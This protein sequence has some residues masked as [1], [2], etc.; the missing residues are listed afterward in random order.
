MKNPLLLLLGAA[1]AQA[2]AAGPP[3]ASGDICRVANNQFTGAHTRGRPLPLLQGDPQHPRAA[4]VVPWSTLSP[5]GHALPV[6]G[7]FEGRLLQLPND[8][9]CGRGTG[10]LW[11]NRRW[12]LTR[13]DT[14]APK[15]ALALCEHL[16]TTTSAATRAFCITQP[17]A[18]VKAAAPAAHSATN[19]VPS[20][21]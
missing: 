8:S 15:D 3:A 9:A 7:C 5:D 11:V 20:R 16:D 10:P 19:P 17:D 13:A 12:V 4:C 21:H 18:P 2:V 14:P 6:A 1:L